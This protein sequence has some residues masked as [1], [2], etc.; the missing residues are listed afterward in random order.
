[1]LFSRNVTRYCASVRLEKIVKIAKDDKFDG[2]LKAIAKVL[3]KKP[4]GL[5]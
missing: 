3:V 2:N 4:N 5:L 1:L